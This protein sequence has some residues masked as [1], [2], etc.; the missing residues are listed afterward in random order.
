MFAENASFFELNGP[1]NEIS[2]FQKNKLKKILNSLNKNDFVYILG[3]VE[4]ELLTQI[5]EILKKKQ[6]KF[7]LDIDTNNIEKFLAFEPYFYKPNIDELRTNFK[8][9]KDDNIL[10]TLKQIQAKGSKNILLSLGQEGCILL[11]EKQNF[12][13]SW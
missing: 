12:Y 2:N 10:Q 11:D 7:G 4:E 13:K 6:V 5:C 3:V 8:L 1:K 9:T